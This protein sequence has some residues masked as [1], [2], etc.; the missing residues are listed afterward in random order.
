[1]QGRRRKITG[2][3]A[4]LPCLPHARQDALLPL[5]TLRAT[6]QR[7]SRTMLVRRRKGEVL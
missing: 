3:V 6:V 1:M 5:A 4:F 7:I 2:G